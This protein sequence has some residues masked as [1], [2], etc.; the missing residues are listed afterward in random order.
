MRADVRQRCTSKDKAQ[1]KKRME[2]KELPDELK[3]IWSIIINMESQVGDLGFALGWAEEHPDQIDV[4]KDFCHGAKNIE[5][6]RSKIESL[7][8]RIYELKIEAERLKMEFAER[9]AT[10]RARARK[11]YA[12]FEDLD[13]GIPPKIHKYSCPYHQRWL[14][15]GSK[16]TTWHPTYTIQEAREICKRIAP[17]KTPIEASCCM[18]AR[19]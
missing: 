19:S 12:V 9:I 16:T 14:N 4:V 11:N 7:K 3:E 2:N 8:D 5:E 18:G 17:G 13:G 15:R 6:I 1:V 10:Q